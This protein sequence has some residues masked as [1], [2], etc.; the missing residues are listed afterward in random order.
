MTT[1]NFTEPSQITLLRIQKD[2]DHKGNGYF[3]SF[4][5]KGHFV[6]TILA[7]QTNIIPKVSLNEDKLKRLGFKLKTHEVTQYLKD[8]DLKI[9]DKCHCITSIHEIEHKDHCEE[10][11]CI[12]PKE[13][14]KV[15]KRMD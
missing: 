5:E 12:E 3:A 2:A 15:N 9:Y 6:K 13:V 10:K 8:K 14:L 7:D 4:D 11:E 1:I